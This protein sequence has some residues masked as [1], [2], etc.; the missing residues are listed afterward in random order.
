VIVPG[1]VRA[2]L[3]AL[4]FICISS[5]ALG[6]GPP[7]TAFLAGQFGGHLAIGLAGTA[8]CSLLGTLIFMSRAAKWLGLE[9]QAVEEAAAPSG[10]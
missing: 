9:I 2:T 10:G 8:L 5:L 7:L 4:A 3:T 1:S 6:I